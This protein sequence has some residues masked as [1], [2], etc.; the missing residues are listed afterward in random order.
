MQGESP[1]GTFDSAFTSVHGGS[2]DNIKAMDLILEFFFSP[3]ELDRAHH[4]AAFR[5]PQD[6]EPEIVLI[7]CGDDFLGRFLLLEVLQ[8]I[9]CRYEAFLM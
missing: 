2:T 9:A 3:A 4:L 1:C 8:R 5:V 6:A 7:T